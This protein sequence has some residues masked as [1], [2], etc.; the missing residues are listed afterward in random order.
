VNYSTFGDTQQRF[1]GNCTYLVKVTGDQFVSVTGT[2]PIKIV[3][4]PGTKNS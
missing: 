3:A 2:Q 4:I 1:P